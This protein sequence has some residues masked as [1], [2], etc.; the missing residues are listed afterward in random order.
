MEAIAK[1][2]GVSKETLY[3]WWR[4]KSEVILDTL[5]GRGRQ[6]IPLPDI[7]T[8]REDLRSFLRATVDSADATTVQLLH[9]VAAAAA[10]DEAVAVQVRDRFLA[11]AGPTSARCSIG[12]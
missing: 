12:P 7:G 9:A 3:R 10:S 1:R 11:P 8:L 6:T 2:A 4:S 5:A